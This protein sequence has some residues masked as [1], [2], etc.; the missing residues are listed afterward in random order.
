MVRNSSSRPGAQGAAAAIEEV[1]SGMGPDAH[2]W[3][4]LGM[5]KNV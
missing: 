1:I 5:Q 3:V 4:V 2:E